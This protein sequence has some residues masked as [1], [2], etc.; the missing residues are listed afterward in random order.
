[1]DKK[2]RNSIVYA[3]MNEVLNEESKKLHTKAV[4]ENEALLKMF[5]SLPEVEKIR[6]LRKE[7]D[8]L[9]AK[10]E[11]TKNAHNTGNPKRQVI[12]SLHRIERNG[13]GGDDGDAFRMYSES[14]NE[15]Y[16]RK[17]DIMEMLVQHRN[18]KNERIAKIAA[19]GLKLIFE[20]DEATIQSFLEM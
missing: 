14:Y 3:K 16:F 13:Y 10:L 9:V 12:L 19:A 1:M 15:C 4:E 17:G 6:A 18:S 11:Q 8:K 7:H 20:G 5:N 2:E